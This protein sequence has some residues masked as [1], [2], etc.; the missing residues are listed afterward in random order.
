[1]LFRIIIACIFISVSHSV[2]ASDE[3]IY[4]HGILVEE[5]CSVSL[6]SSDQTVRLGNIIKNM[7]YLHKRTQSF[8][9][10][11]ILEECDTTIGSL[12]EITFNGEPDEAQP[13]MLAVEG[14]AK[15]I[16]IGLENFSG[17]P[18]ILNKTIE[19]YT[20]NEG[21]MVLRFFA[22]VSAANSVIEKKEIV[23]G[24][25]TAS[26]TFALNYP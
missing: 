6:H 24:N 15:G 22:Y 23:E 5:P 10:S 4:L 19:R 18:I 16:S 25:F 11:I 2:E 9:F 7:L 14:T 12:V 17:T 1:M 26:M 13:N 20:L 8:P 3:N 21:Q